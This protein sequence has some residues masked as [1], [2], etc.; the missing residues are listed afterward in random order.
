MLKSFSGREISKLAVAWQAAAYGSDDGNLT[1]E[2]MD[3]V[4]EIAM[5]QHHQKLDWR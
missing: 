3:V 1:E 5:A 4:V 2:M